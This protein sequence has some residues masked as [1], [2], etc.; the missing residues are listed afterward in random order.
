MSSTAALVPQQTLPQSFEDMARHLRVANYPAPRVIIDQEPGVGAQF[1]LAV[2]HLGFAGV[3]IW[4][5]L[6]AL[7]N[8]VNIAAGRRLARIPRTTLFALSTSGLVGWAGFF[9]VSCLFI[10]R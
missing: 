2:M 1:V 8:A 4:H 5:A 7:P 10:W 9:A 3:L 6:R